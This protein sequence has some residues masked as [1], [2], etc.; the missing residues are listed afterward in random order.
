MSKEPHPTLQTFAETRDEVCF[1]KLFEEFG[2]LVYSGAFRRTGDRQLAEEITQN[3]F[4]A[5]ASKAKLVAA[6]PSLTG[7]LF[8]ATQLEA[9][10]TL[11]AHHRHTQKVQTLAEQEH[12]HGMATTNDE[13]WREAL[14][15]LYASLDR[16]KR[17]DRELIL[18][19]YFSGQSFREVAESAGC[20]EAACKMRVRRSLDKLQGWLSQRGVVLSTAAFATGLTTE[21]GQAAPTQFLA[22]LPAK[23]LSTA[24]A[25]GAGNVIT[26]SIMAMNL[27]KPTAIALTVLALASVPFI[28]QRSESKMIRER[29]ALH[30]SEKTTRSTSVTP[31]SRAVVEEPP[32]MRRF[33]AALEQQAPTANELL[34]ELESAMQTQNLAK[35]I[36]IL[37]PLVRLSNEDLQ[38]L[39]DGVATN[40]DHPKAKGMALQVLANLESCQDSHRRLLD[41]ILSSEV[42]GPRKELPTLFTQWAGRDYPAAF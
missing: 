3:V 18:A 27:T 38:A 36:R 8:T 9:L 32:P 13:I 16:L 21:F 12:Q 34:S 14:P 15:D 33:L 17:K 28:A 25:V 42:E 5:L 26:Q 19:R 2:G 11:R 7:W 1:S 4:V 6:H 35:A 31:Q 10:R 39:S 30:Q 23:A 37:L 41:K 20:S 24:P 22:S 29:I 40:Q